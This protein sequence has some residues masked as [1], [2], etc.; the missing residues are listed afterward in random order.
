MWQELLENCAI[1]APNGRSSKTTFLVI[2]SMRS[3]VLHRTAEPQEA[4]WHYLS[5]T[6]FAD[7]KYSHRLVTGINTLS[8][9]FTLY[10]ASSI[11]YFRFAC[12]TSRT[13][14]SWRR[15]WNATRTSSHWSR[16]TG[17][18]CGWH[19]TTLSCCGEPI[20]CS[21]SLT[22]R[23][24]HCLDPWVINLFPRSFPLM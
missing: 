17:T 11:Y 6:S 21:L 16:I 10:N 2:L 12:R 1:N 5:A 22:Q 4:L 18:S 3:L 8:T 24:C 20:Y 9:R 15:P 7:C 23:Y 14:C 19:L 13:R